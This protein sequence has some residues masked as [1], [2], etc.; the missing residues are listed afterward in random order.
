MNEL[1]EI[2]GQYPLDWK[3]CLVKDH[4]VYFSKTTRTKYTEMTGKMPPHI[5]MLARHIASSRVLESL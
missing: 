4:Y 5:V 1:I 3:L 2:K